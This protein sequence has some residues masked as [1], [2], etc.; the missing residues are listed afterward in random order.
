MN[1]KKLKIGFVGAGKQAQCAHIRNYATLGDCTL[2]AIADRDEVL[3]DKVAER[4]GI[5]K[6]YASHQEMLAKEQLDAIVVT[7]P[8]IPAA[9]PVVCDILA[10]HIPVFVEKPLAYSVP[11][12]ERVVA[13]AKKYGTLLV[14]GYHKRS[15][16]ATMFAKKEIDRLKQT[17]ELGKLRYAR[18]HVS[19]A[20]DWISGGYLD[21]IKGSAPAPAAAPLPMDEFAGMNDKML[22]NYRS[23]AGAHSHQFDL[24]R[25]LI[26]EDYRFAYVQPSGILLV[27][28]SENK[29]PG[30]FEFT[31]YA[32]T[33]DW[34][35][36]ALVAFERGFVRVS[37]PAP[38]TNNLA[39]CVEV[40][41]DEGGTA[42]P[43]TTTPVFPARSALQ[44][45]AVNF[46]EMVRGNGGVMCGPEDAL[47]SLVI[48]RDWA[49]HLQ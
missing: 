33:K 29:I 9:E 1:F 41:R 16:P 48:A 8:S 4:Y 23:F 19:L 30:T 45:Q 11:A 34:R 31:P 20:G 46:L 7:L 28:E 5:G 27:I 13:A 43:L 14:V 24:M 22:M 2:A 47:K 42:I 21:A 49:L 25:H 17:G 37:L 15:D 26:G 38:V 10:A 35:E 3:A 40:F 32:S 12:A 39:G 6:V 36:S 18:V 44:Q